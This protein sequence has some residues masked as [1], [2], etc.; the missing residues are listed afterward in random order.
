MRS[1]WLCLQ[2]LAAA[3]CATV[4]QATSRATVLAIDEQQRALV[5]AEDA[6]GLERL[7]HANLRINAPG[8]H[9]LSREQF[10]K[11]MRS[12]EIGAEA[13]ERTPE[14]VSISGKVAVVMGHEVFT[15]KLESELGRIY[16][17]KPLR[18]RY[19]NVYVW[20]HGHW[21]WLARQA[22]VVADPRK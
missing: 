22:D 16:G 19:T 3:G 4:P 11:N 7:A 13:F 10:L 2:L 8:G 18:R 14:D 20:E 5:A 1:A 17:A 9:V 15:P 6:A 21:L 12:G